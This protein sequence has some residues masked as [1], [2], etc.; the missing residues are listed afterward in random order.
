MDIASRK[1]YEKDCDMIHNWEGTN[2]ENAEIKNI[3]ISKRGIPAR[4]IHAKSLVLTNTIQ[5][6]PPE[7]ISLSI[8]FVDPFETSFRARQPD[9]EAADDRTGFQACANA[10]IMQT[11]YMMEKNYTEIAKTGWNTS[12][13]IQLYKR[14]GCPG[15]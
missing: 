12:E 2:G 9:C 4:L 13:H 10:E 11:T 7:H 8:K 14:A 5:T 15:R 3:L 6:L 1:R